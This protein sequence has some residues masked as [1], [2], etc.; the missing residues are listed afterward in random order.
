MSKFISKVPDKYKKFI[1]NNLTTNQIKQLHDMYTDVVN[2]I[3][4]EISKFKK[5]RHEKDVNVCD[6]V[7]NHMI[8]LNNVMY[9]INDFYKK[10]TLEKT[11][12]IVYGRKVKDM[13]TSYKE[14]H[15]SLTSIVNISISIINAIIYYCKC[16]DQLC[17][18]KVDAVITNKLF[19]IRG[20]KA[21]FTKMAYV[22]GSADCKDMTAF[23]Q[24]MKPD[25]TNIMHDLYEEDLD[26]L[27]EINEDDHLLTYYAKSVD[28]VKIANTLD[29]MITTFKHM[30]TCDF[31]KR[32]FIS[33]HKDGC[34][35]I[36]KMHDDILF[37]VTIAEN[38]MAFVLNKLIADV[39]SICGTYG[40][41]TGVRN[42]FINKIE[43]GIKAMYGKYD[44]WF[45]G[46]IAIVVVLFIALC[47]GVIIIKY[48]H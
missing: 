19:N 20:K 37:G 29:K 24:Y 4:I 43:N 16:L 17:D 25:L 6:I 18:Y 42:K 35:V 47:S 41:G 26:D 12:K 32:E 45:I 3:I 2:I 8:L 9:H 28:F 22:N 1:P 39:E 33:K 46:I 36:H 38:T 48:G 31:I 27:E 7:K 34:N 15:T 44:G 5:T 11:L 10:A 30:V 40:V 13:C 21:S 23:E 14:L